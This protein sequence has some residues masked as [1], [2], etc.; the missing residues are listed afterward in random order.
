MTTEKAEKVMAAMDLSQEEF[1]RIPLQMALQLHRLVDTCAD[2]VACDAPTFDAGCDWGSTEWLEG[3][4][5]VIDKARRALHPKFVEIVE[6]VEKQQT[7]EPMN[8]NEP[9]TDVLGETVR[10]QGDQPRI[11][12]L[13]L[14]TSGMWRFRWAVA[15]GI[16][17]IQCA[18]KQKFGNNYAR[19][20]LVVCASS[21][22]GLNV[23]TVVAAPIG[24]DWVVLG[25]A[26]IIATSSGYLWVKLRNFAADVP[27]EFDF[28]KTT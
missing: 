2:L 10:D 23:D 21:K 11:G 6:I 7:K 14:D 3:V 18:V 22:V 25:P 4:Q 1:D 13:L 19:P 9:K 16:R 17:S 12:N 26:T 28:V 20:E 5:H 15:P 8:T 27:A 24:D